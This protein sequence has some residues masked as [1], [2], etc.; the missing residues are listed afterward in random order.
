M[1][2]YLNRTEKEKIELAQSICHFMNDLV[3]FDKDAIHALIETRIICNQELANH[4]TVQ[5]LQPKNSEI[6]SVGLLGILNGFI[7]IDENQ[8]GYIAANFDENNQLIG[9]DLRSNFK[10]VPE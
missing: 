3:K 10:E 2:N 7:G 8:L 1:N 4:P 5:V 9:F 6:A